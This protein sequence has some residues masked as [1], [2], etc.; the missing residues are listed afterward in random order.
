MTTSDSRPHKAHGVDDSLARHGALSYLEVPASD[1]AQSATFYERVVGWKVD[2]SDPS[3]PKFS[4]PFGNLIGRW[5]TGRAPSREPGLVLYIYV[6]RIHDAV[7]RVAAHGGEVVRAP[8]AEG[9]VLVATIRDP[10]GNLIG[11]W[12]DASRSS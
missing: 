6:D 4:D 5:Q 1:P 12:Q 7:G 11:L 8:Y 2:R 10:A 9:D 3:R